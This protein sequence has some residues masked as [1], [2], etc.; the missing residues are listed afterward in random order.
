MLTVLADI[1]DAD[2]VVVA[3]A[4][5]LA[6]ATLLSAQTVKS[7]LKELTDERLIVKTLR[8]SPKEHEAESHIQ[9]VGWQL[10]THGENITSSLV[11]AG[12]AKTRSGQPLAVVE[13]ARG[14]GFS[15]GDILTNEGL[16]AA[17]REAVESEWQGSVV[18][19]IAVA[20]E[21]TVKTRLAW[22]VRRRAG[23]D[24]SDAQ[25]D[26]ASHIWEVLRVNHEKILAADQPWGLTVVITAKAIAKRDEHESLKAVPV[27]EFHGE[28]LNLGSCSET[29]MKSVSFDD[30]DET[31][32][33]L[34][35]IDLLI[36]AGVREEAAREGIRRVLEIAAQTSA[37]RRITRARADSQLRDVG[38]TEVSAGALMS[39]IAGTRRGGEEES[40]F[41][42][43]SQGGTGVTVT[44]SRRIDRV[45]VSRVR[46]CGRGS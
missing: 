32:P 37:G 29:G 10:P 21:V 25:M 34:Q 36:S 15:H 2:G 39:L 40:M 13:P 18:D 28:V 3:S 33:V 4:D 44:E 35:I 41:L 12:S 16:R 11:P 5:F 24:F 7:V 46:L 43:L 26:V 17:L 14:G 23:F 30:V 9:L 6:D 38:F 19:A 42:R 20:I 22:L 45:A 8:R 1:A 31:G 27:D